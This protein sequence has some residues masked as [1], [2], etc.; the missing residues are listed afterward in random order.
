[1][2]T[3]VNNSNYTGAASGMLVV[4]QGGATVVLGSLAQTYTGSALPV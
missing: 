1:M 3:T 4:A 2:V